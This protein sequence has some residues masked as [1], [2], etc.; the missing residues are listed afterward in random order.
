MMRKATRPK[1]PIDATT[2]M[3]TVQSGGFGSIGRETIQVKWDKD[4]MPYNNAVISTEHLKNAFYGW[5]QKLR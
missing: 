3:S 4:I 2:A 5:K 1:P